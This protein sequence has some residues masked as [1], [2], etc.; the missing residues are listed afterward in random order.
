MTT[1]NPAT[2]ILFKTLS[3]ATRTRTSTWKIQPEQV[4][5]FSFPELKFEPFE[6]RLFD[7]K[8]INCKITIHP[9]CLCLKEILKHWNRYSWPSWTKF[10]NIKAYCLIG[11]QCLIMEHFSRRKCDNTIGQPQSSKSWVVFCYG[12]IFAL[13]KCFF[14]W[15]TA[16]V[17]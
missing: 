9:G 4:T 15:G 13:I 8:S 12:K 11:S 16:I 5:T 1:K 14:E 3:P 10:V 17:V 2:K 7:L 6:G